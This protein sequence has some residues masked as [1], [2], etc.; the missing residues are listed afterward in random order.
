MLSLSVSLFFLFCFFLMI[1]PPTTFT[2]SYPPLPLTTLIP[3]TKATEQQPETVTH[4]LHRD[5]VD[6]LPLEGLERLLP[7][8]PIEIGAGVPPQIDAFFLRL[9]FGNRRN[10]SV[11]ILQPQKLSSARSEEHTSE[12]QSLMRISYA[13]FCLKQKTHHQ[14]HNH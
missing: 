2:R 13:V 5:P 7:A 12:L 3:S 8:E 6:L 10:V 4:R 1:P 14:T 9:T 11:D